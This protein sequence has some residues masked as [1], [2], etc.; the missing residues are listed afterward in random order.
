VFVCTGSIYHLATYSLV[1]VWSLQLRC[2]P[3]S[4][5]VLWALP[6]RAT[7][8]HTR[9]SLCSFHVHGGVCW[10]PIPGGKAPIL[11]IP[12]RDGV[13]SS[14]ERWT[15]LHIRVGRMHMPSPARLQRCSFGP[16]SLRGCWLE[17]P[18]SP[19]RRKSFVALYDRGDV[20]LPGTSV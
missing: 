12:Y 14:I 19:L 2:L 13:R 7:A 4:G 5:F 10:R 8:K 15:S 11:A 1:M 3:V 20:P 18:N 6:F 9:L 17:L 16:S